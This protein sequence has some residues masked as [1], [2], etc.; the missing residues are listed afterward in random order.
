MTRS[1]Y[2][3][4]GYVQKLHTAQ[5]AIAM[6]RPGKRVFIGSATGEPQELVRALSAATMRLSG[7]EVVRLMSLETTSLSEIAD[8]TLDHSLNIRTIYL[9][10][11]DTEAIA[12][13]MRFIT[14]MNMSEIPGLFL[15]RKLPIHVALI[16]VT[17][18]DDFGWMSLGVS[19]D[20]TL[21]AAQ[22][23][24]LVIAQ[25]NPRMPR[26]MGQSF[27]HVNNVHVLVEHEEPLLTAELRKRSGAAEWIGKHIARFVEDGSTLQIGLDAASQAT[28][29]G[30]ADKNDL[31]FHS[32]Y[33]TDDV[34][35]LYAKGVIT[36]RKK[37]LNE[38]KLVASCAIGSENLYEFLHDNPGVDFRP[39]DYIN[40]PFIIGQHNRMISMNVAHT[41]D[42]T[43][44]VA[45]E[46]SKHTFFAGVSG[47]P[48]FVRGAKRSKGG[49]SIL[50]LYSA[51]KDG[52]RSRIVPSLDSTAVVVPRGDVHYVVTEYGAVNLFGKSLQER[53]LA[54]IGIAH[55]DHRDWLFNAAK[56]A[57]LIGGERHL[58]EAT[59]GIYPIHLEETI[60]RD[61][62]EITIRPS[63]PVDERRIQEHYYN[64]N[65]KD[66]QLRFF[67]D[68]NSFDRSDVETR[69]QI[70]YI[71]DLTLVAIVGE[72]GFGKVIGVGEYLLLIESNIAEV[73]FSISTAY[74]GKGLGKLFLRKLARAARENGISGLVAY[75]A[76]QNKAMV[77]LFKTLPYK[78]K[79]TFDGESLMLK[80]R[81]DEMADPVGA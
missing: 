81:F 72:F 29:K 47:I 8:K 70:D 37:G 78:V 64:L 18:P 30:L 38:G 4:D 66:V 74:Q 42:L 28:V 11:A 27:I 56:E 59:K 36:N 75:T 80:C 10:S 45:A 35:H 49:K 17:P 54:L 1:L 43:G 48:D 55:P 22:S 71:K 3:A 34:M 63:K 69:S 44:Q 40:D 61:G 23:A 9:G 65:K 14:P 7:L 52:K 46:A 73:A 25:V 20:V 60:V 13:Y 6:I 68:K 39:S 57:R 15:T 79:T 31:G 50:M 26:T 76:P 24:D 12:R 51:S 41:I 21:A 53:V 62:E 32:Q 33:I 16:Q 67:H 19:V 58:G 2:W 5:E 77:A